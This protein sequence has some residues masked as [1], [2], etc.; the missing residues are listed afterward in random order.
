M[1]RSLLVISVNIEFIVNNECIVQGDSMMQF[2]FKS[3]K[4]KR[5]RMGKMLTLFF[6]VKNASLK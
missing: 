4:S 2:R 5:K 3:A 1:K 6:Q